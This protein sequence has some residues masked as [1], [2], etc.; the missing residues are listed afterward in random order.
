MREL[1]K[2]ENATGSLVPGGSC[3]C[4]EDAEFFLYCDGGCAAHGGTEGGE[5]S[6]DHLNSYNSALAK[7]NPLASIE[8]KNAE[9]DGP[10]MDTIFSGLVRDNDPRSQWRAVRTHKFH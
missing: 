1:G 10:K 6:G 3:A 5:L 2:A 4:D 7:F 8:A 9:P